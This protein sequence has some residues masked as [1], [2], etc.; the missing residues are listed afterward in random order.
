MDE[1]NSTFEPIGMCFNHVLS[2]IAQTPT[3]CGCIQFHR[4]HYASLESNGN[5]KIGVYD[6]GCVS[7]TGENVEL[8]WHAETEEA[9]ENFQKKKLW[10]AP[11][12]IRVH[13]KRHH[14]PPTKLRVSWSANLYGNF[15]TI[16]MTQFSMLGR[17]INF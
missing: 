9:K 3:P 2:C 16:I 14:N 11:K 15:V 5:L 8:L 7:H 1:N 13:S 17:V 10:V 12:L 6:F 4:Q